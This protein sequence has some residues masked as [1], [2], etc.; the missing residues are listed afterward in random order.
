MKF[1]KTVQP[2]ETITAACLPNFLLQEQENQDID[3]LLQEHRESLKKK[4]NILADQEDTETRFS[5]QEQDLVA[6]DPVKE[7]GS[8]LER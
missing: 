5:S 1:W 8:G 2:A 3:S 6:S 7:T 4:R